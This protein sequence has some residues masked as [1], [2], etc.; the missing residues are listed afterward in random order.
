MI[1]LVMGVEGSGK[2]TVGRALAAAQGWVFADGD[3]FHSAGNKK[4]LHLGIAL[5]DEDRAPWLEAMHAAIL[6]WHDLSTNVVLAA[7]ALRETYREQ[8]FLGVPSSGYRIVYLEG[9]QQTLEDRLRTRVGHFASPE[10]LSSQLAT[11]EP[12]RNAITISISQT[13]EQQVDKIRAAL[14]G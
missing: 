9:S 13:V 7:S 6:R 11:L 1:V 14:R 10:I 2:S 5:T 4:K 8:M 12:P 3:D